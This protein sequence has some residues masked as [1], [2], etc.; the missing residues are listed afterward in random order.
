VPRIRVGLV[1]AALLLAGCG[2]E[3]STPAPAQNQTLTVYAAA[4]LKGTFTELGRQFER[5]HA[6]TEVK[7]SFGG[8]SDLV[9][10]LQQGAPADVFAS[11]DTKNMTKATD[12]DLVAGDPVDFASNTLEIA[13]PP[14][15]PAEITSFAD[16][17]KPGV[18][19]V[20]CA[21]QVPCGS[22]TQ[23][24]EAATGITLHPVSEEN[25]VTDVLNKVTSGEA[26]AGLVYKTDVRSAAGKADGV[27]FPEAN[28]A[29]NVYPIAV[30][31]GST[32]P[33]L[34]QD[35]VDLV[36]GDQGRQVLADAGFSSPSP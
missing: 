30:L 19:L 2:V 4:S 7:L 1:A 28:Q 21:P 35:F 9:T 22:A 16:L 31:A 34:A 18:K 14:N 20:T 24:V 13:V 11:A 27:A 15:N 33:E 25:S 8:S 12:D 3:P 5:T 36:T 23:K 17:A 6:G 10:Q 32:N 29:V 26:D